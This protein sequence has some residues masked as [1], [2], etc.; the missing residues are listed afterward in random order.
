MIIFCCICSTQY[1]LWYVPCVIINFNKL[2]CYIAIA[3]AVCLPFSLHISLSLFLLLVFLGW[4]RNNSHHF[5]EVEIKTNRRGVN[6]ALH[7]DQK[8]KMNDKKIV[9]WS[10]CFN[11]FFSVVVVL[12]CWVVCVWLFNFE[13][14]FCLFWMPEHLLAGPMHLLHFSNECHR[15]CF[16]WCVCNVCTLKQCIVASTGKWVS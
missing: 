2:H 12:L 13:I 7:T 8:Y 10:F 6:N 11:F 3:V 15:V 1:V 5:Y 14:Q 9:G 4:Y 16:K